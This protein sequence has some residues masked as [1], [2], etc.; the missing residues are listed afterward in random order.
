MFSKYKNITPKRII[1]RLRMLFKGIKK[2]K[3]TEIKQRKNKPKIPV[4]PR[5]LLI[6]PKKI[7]L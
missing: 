5:E 1:I 2:C 3:N 7:F 6:F 4:S